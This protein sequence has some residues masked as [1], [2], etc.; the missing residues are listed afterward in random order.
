MSNEQ[1]EH[2]RLYF[3][4]EVLP[5]TAVA[6]LVCE[7]EH[8]KEY[9]THIHNSPV[10]G[11]VQT[12]SFVWDI[13]IVPN[14]LGNLETRIRDSL[15]N[16]LKQPF[17]AALDVGRQRFPSA[18]EGM[19]YFPANYERPDPSKLLPRTSGDLCGVITINQTDIDQWRVRMDS[20][21]HPEVWFEVTLSFNTKV[22]DYKIKNIQGRLS[23]TGYSELHATLDHGILQVTDTAHPER[24]AAV[25]LCKDLSRYERYQERQALRKSKLRAN[26]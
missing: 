21:V 14:Y 6:L 16:H 3:L 11:V 19:C 10:E 4:H 17:T 13:P 5:I 15:P 8:G 22:R 18:T 7:Y 23:S 1:I 9:A 25:Q 12:G 26:Q 20:R 24:Y 2:P